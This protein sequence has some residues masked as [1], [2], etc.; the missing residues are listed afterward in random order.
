MCNFK[1]NFKRKDSIESQNRIVESK[2]EL[3]IVT[4]RILHY[5][6]ILSV[7]KKGEINHYRE[8]LRAHRA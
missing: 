6:A 7:T 8:S 2:L 4:P 5:S 3:V 1:H